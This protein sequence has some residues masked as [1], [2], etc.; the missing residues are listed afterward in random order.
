MPVLG[1][2][3]GAC[4]CPG[5]SK[6][7]SGRNA[8]SKHIAVYVRVSSRQQDMASQRPDLERYAKAQDLP[9]VWYTDTFT[10]R[11]MNRPGWNKLLNAMQK[12]EVAAVVVWRLDRLGRT[13][14]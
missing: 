9:V 14:R 3:D 13:A 7:D 1:P 4:W 11:T 12:G 2:P 6:N 8:M 5:W 10:G